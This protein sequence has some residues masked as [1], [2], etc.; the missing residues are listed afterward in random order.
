MRS[1]NEF[2]VIVNCAIGGGILNESA[3]NRV[4]ELKTRVIADFDLNAEWF[5]ARLN[6][7]DCL[8]MAIICDEERFPTWN[9]CVAKRHRFRGG[10]GFVQEG[11]IC[12][13]ERRQVDDHLLK[14]EQ[15][16][17]PALRDFG[18]IR[19]VSGV[20]AR[21]FENVSLDDR[22]RN[23]VVVT[24]ANKRSSHLVL[25]GNRAE[26]SERFGIQF[27]FGQ[28][29]LPIQANVF[30]NSGIDEQIETF[31]AQLVQHLG[32]FSF[33]RADVATRERIQIDILFARLHWRR[34]RIVT[35][36]STL[37]MWERPQCPDEFA[38]LRL[39]PH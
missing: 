36:S 24:G 25:P 5:R 35:R 39:L 15:R 16:F 21:I 30:W 31:E 10:R 26:L 33:A 12:D 7:G 3:E 18:L 27:R 19:R 34:L 4:V 1:R 9:S 13:V 32:Y 37:Q 29:Q 6:D 23:A 20:P 2:G 17:E 11:R 28:L 14:I 22:W 8:W 38:A